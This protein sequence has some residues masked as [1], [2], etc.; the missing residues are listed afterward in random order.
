MKK[1]N[2]HTMA[3]FAEMKTDYEGMTNLMLD[4][5]LGREI[6]A[7]G[8]KISKSDANAKI[9][10]FSRKVLDITDIKDTDIKKHHDSTITLSAT[11][12]ISVYATKD[13]YENSDVVTATLCWI[14]QEPKTEGITN[15]EA[16]VP[17]KALLIQNSG[18]II[19]V[20]GADD[21]EHISIYGVNGME[22]GSAISQNGMATINTSLQTGSVAI[23]KSGQKSIKVILK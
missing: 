17:A 5:A 12:N 11:Y 21:G 15:S 8:E 19:N 7:D 14:D 18:G 22:V 10:D 16:N 4:V 2:E 1:F 6:Y 3:V 23:V 9:L 20:Q 13:G